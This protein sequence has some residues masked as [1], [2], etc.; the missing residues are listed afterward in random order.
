VSVPAGHAVER[1]AGGVLAD[2][3]AGEGLDEAA[4]EE[5]AVVAQEVL[6]QERED[7]RLRAQRCRA[8]A[9]AAA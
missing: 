8:A 5:R 4:G 3:D 6:G 2:A 1:G 9:R 7:D